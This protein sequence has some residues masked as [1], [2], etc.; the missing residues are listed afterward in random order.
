MIVLFKWLSF[1]NLQWI[2]WI[3]M[4]SCPLGVYFS[5]LRFFVMNMQDTDISQEEWF[6]ISLII[7]LMSIYHNLIY[8][9]IYISRAL[10]DCMFVWQCKCDSSSLVT[11]CY[12][13]FVI[14]ALNF[15]FCNIKTKFEIRSCYCL[16]KASSDV[17]KKF[18]VIKSDVFFFIYGD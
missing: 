1:E 5:G 6:I 14:Q 16:L 13:V 11:I 18:Y 10:E 3:F 17:K 7:H 2:V 15:S 4:L 9:A 8:V 12:P